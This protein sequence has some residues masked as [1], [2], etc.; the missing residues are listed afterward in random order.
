MH[1][2][3]RQKGGDIKREGSFVL[4]RLSLLS[5]LICPHALAAVGRN[6]KLEEHPAHALDY[7]FFP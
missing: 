1:D 3:E 5:F 2:F 4:A 7:T 6:G